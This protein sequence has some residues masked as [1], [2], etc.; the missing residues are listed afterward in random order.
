MSSS[1][2]TPP[3]TNATRL[4]RKR[5][6]NSAD[7]ERIAGVASTTSLMRSWPGLFPPSSQPDLRVHH[8]VQQIDDQIDQHELAREQKNLR[9]DNGIV[10]IGH[11]V[12]QQSAQSR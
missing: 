4:R 9:L 3:D 12:D 10:A 7:G 1:S 8:R 5:R 11:A 6:Q 2:S